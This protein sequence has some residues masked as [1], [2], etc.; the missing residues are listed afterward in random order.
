V[1]E[2]DPAAGAA[3]TARISGQEPVSGVVMFVLLMSLIL[4]LDETAVH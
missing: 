1:T 4:W 2:L 3:L